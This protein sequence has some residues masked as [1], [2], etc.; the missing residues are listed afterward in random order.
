[1]RILLPLVGLVALFGCKSNQVP[2]SYPDISV[3]A[4][5]ELVASEPDVVVLDIRTPGEYDAGHLPGA[6]MVD[7]KAADFVEQLK[8]LDPSKTYVMH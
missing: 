6:V 7:C 3:E 1:M 2:E 4:A 5:A 8:Q